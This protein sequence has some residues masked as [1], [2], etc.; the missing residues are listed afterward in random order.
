MGNLGT[1]GQGNPWLEHHILLHFCQA[2]PNSSWT[3]LAL[4]SLNP[5]THTYRLIPPTPNHPFHPKLPTHPTPPQKLSLSAKIITIPPKLE[6]Y[7][8]GPYP[9]GW[10]ALKKVSIAGYLATAG[11]GSPYLT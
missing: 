11:F 8:F 9:A 1:T 6:S 4:V 7:V 5:S 10:L 2:Q 3:E